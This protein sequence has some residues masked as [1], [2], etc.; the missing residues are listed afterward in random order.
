MWSSEAEPALVECIA[1]GCR[2]PRSDA[3]EYDRYGNRWNRAG[4][5]FEYLCKPCHAM[6]CHQPRG[7]LENTLVDVGAVHAT[8]ASFV[9]AYY[10]VLRERG[11]EEHPD[12]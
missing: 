5:R 6:E 2:L 11:S 1:C 8:P 3:R 9:S 7:G 4:K 10:A 12:A